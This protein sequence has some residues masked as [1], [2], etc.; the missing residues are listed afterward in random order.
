[1][2][3]LIKKEKLFGLQSLDTYK[4]FEKKV[5][6]IKHDLLNFL[7]KMKKEG[8]SVVGY[9]AAAKGNTLLNYMGIK[10]D[11]IHYI[12]DASKSK[13]NKYMPGHIKILSPEILETSPPDYI[14][15]LPWNLSK[16]IIETYRHLT[17]KGT[18]FLRA[19]PKLEFL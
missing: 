4:E 7:L 18:Q 5:F 12:C 19:I 8:K 10:S 11:L 17:K 15:I 6:I 3:N 1:M 13:Q 2:P 14:L 9:G 16:E